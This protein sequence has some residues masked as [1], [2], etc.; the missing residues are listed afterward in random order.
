MPTSTTD[1]AESA[2]A[3]DAAAMFGAAL[4]EAEQYA[5]LLTGVGMERGLVGPGEAARI[6]DEE[7]RMLR[8]TKD[9]AA[10]V[11]AFRERRDPVFTRS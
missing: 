8:G 3:A 1:G 6:W 9:H 5:G 10:A 4:G 7:L 2:V 11:E